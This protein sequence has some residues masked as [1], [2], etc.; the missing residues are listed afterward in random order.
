MV[1][2][3][4]TRRNIPEDTILDSHRR[5]DLK[6]FVILLVFYFLSRCICI[7]LHHSLSVSLVRNRMFPLPFPRLILLTQAIGT[8][9]PRSVLPSGAPQEEEKINK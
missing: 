9:V 3:R 1:L 2:T 8:P 5:E 4:A 6:F 7:S